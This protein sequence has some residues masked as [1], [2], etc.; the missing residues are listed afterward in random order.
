LEKYLS[1]LNDKI[2]VPA[3]YQKALSDV[4]EEIQWADDNIW[5]CNNV[6]FSTGVGGQVKMAAVL[7]HH[8]DKNQKYDFVLTDITA[9]FELGDDI[10][11]VNKSKSVLGGIYE[12]DE[13]KIVHVPRNITPED[14]K[15]VMSFFQ[16]VSMKTIAENLGIKV[17]DP[18]K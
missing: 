12:S 2:K 17:E 6:I 3:K 8:D 13:D 16:I 18:W 5:Q 1:H 14:I 15:A 11:I 9:T 4:I 10:L 7:A